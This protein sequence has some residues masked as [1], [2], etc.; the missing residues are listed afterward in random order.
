MTRRDF[1]II[2]AV[3]AAL[4]VKPLAKIAIAD[5]MADALERNFP[6]FKRAKFLKDCGVPE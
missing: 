6:K 3:I 4:K 2:A 1:K 5:D